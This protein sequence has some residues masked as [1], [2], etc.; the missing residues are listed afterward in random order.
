MV[1]IFIDD[2]W[3]RNENFF[4]LV[5][6]NLI[7]CTFLMTDTYLRLPYYKYSINIYYFFL[8]FF[9]FWTSFINLLQYFIPISNMKENVYLVILLG[10]VFII[11]C[12][13]S[14]HN[15]IYQIILQNSQKF[16]NNEHQQE[17]KIRYFYRLIKSS[18]KNKR[19]ELL[20]TSLV[21]HHFLN[22]SDSACICKT[23]KDKKKYTASVQKK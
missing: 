21:E 23:R 18:K 5:C 17:K 19:K 4:L 7:V 11:W 9:Y 22:C 1:L 12:F 6:L 20:L 10:L 15:Q 2:L 3:C 13:L 16:L 14:Y 8:I